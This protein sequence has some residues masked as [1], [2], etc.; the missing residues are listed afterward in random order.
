MRRGYNRSL[1]WDDQRPRT[2]VADILTALA[3]LALPVRAIGCAERQ[4]WKGGR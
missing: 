1:S 4:W 3:D 2:E